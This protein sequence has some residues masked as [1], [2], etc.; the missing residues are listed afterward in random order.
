MLII[1]LSSKLQHCNVVNC[2]LLTDISIL[3]IAHYCRDLRYLSQRRTLQKD[4]RRIN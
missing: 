3:A 1:Q 2:G 4:N